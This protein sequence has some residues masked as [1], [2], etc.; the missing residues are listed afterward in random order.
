MRRK[1]SCGEGTFGRSVPPP[2]RGQAALGAHVPGVLEVPHCQRPIG[3]REPRLLEVARRAVL[4]CLRHLL[5]HTISLRVARDAV[6]VR[7]V[8]HVA[9]PRD[10]AAV[11]A[12]QP[13]DV[14]FLLEAP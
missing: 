4:D 13:A 9:S 7:D 5:D 8:K 12:V 1:V 6:V 14:A 2:W 11:I 10:L 3:M